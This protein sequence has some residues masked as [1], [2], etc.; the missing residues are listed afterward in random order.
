M[1][2]S[3]ATSFPSGKWIGRRLGVALVLAGIVGGIAWIVHHGKRSQAAAAATMGPA[4][5]GGA[6]AVGVATATSG[7]IQIRL[8]ALGTVSPLAT[9]TV[10]TQISG[11]LQVIA[12]KEGSLVQRGDFLA[13]IDARP[14]Q[15]ALRLAEG[16]LAR[17]QAQLANVK[18]DLKRFQ[19]LIKA[20]IVSQQQL[21]T[22]AA[23]IGQS[24]GTVA[25]D[26]AQVETAKLNVR[27]THI[28]APIAG[29]VG[30]RQ[31]DQGNYVTPGDA[32]GIVVVTQLEPITV[33]FSV[34]EDNVANVM[35]RF[36]SGGTLLVDAFDRANTTR[37]AQ[38]KLVSI[39]N[40]IDPTTGT[41]KLRA[42]FNNQDDALF[43]N[44]FVNIQLLV[45]TQRNQ[46][47]IPV[48]ASQ[49]GARNGVA[50]TF[51][52][53]VRADQTVSVHPVTLGTVDGERVA[54]TQ[55]IQVGDMVVTEGADRLKDG[56]TVL[57]PKIISP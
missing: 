21:D 43:A 40:E 50:T 41:V 13:Q 57:L 44:Q 11:Q 4:A 52:Y 14:Y 45:D 15:A 22:Q 32:N 6:V 30:L 27:Y 38:G 12:F 20:N 8:P 39:D 24:T 29:R 23:L 2:E 49:H 54:V 53:V 19:D 51:V 25:S 17:D 33:I 7:D 36:R 37:L 10:K 26:L 46:T 31:V 56:A 1:A 16:N 42:L 55:G 34:P 35:R 47:I 48:A 9:V 18:L 28:V 5:N 3:P